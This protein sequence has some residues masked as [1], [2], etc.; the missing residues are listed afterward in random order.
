MEKFY[1]TTTLPYVNAA[2]HI[3]H[4][5]EFT[6]ADARARFESLS[7]KEVFFNTGSDEHGLKIEQQA[8]ESGLSPKEFVDERH[9]P[10]MKLL[11]ALSIKP[12]CFTRTSSE[13]QIKAAQEFWKICSDNGDIYKATYTGKYCVG[14]ELFLQEK[15]LI[16][17]ICPSHPQTKISEVSEENYMFKLSRSR[18]ALISYYSDNEDSIIPQTRRKELLSFIKESVIDIPISRPSGRV[19]WG[20]PVPGDDT[21]TMHV[22]FDALVNYISALGWPNSGWDS[23]WPG[24]Q[25]S[26]KDNLRPQAL[27]WQ[28]MLFSAQ[29]PMTKQ[30]YVHG[31][32]TLNG[33]KM[34][35]TSGNAVDPFEIIEKYGSE[36]ARWLMLSFN[37][38]EDS[39]FSWEKAEEQYVAEFVK[40]VGNTTARVMALAETHLDKPV[41]KKHSFD[42]E[43]IEAFKS[44]N[45]KLAT[46]HVLSQ[47]KKIDERISSKKPFSII[48]ED[49]EKGVEEI[50]ALVELLGHCAHHISPL[51]P[52]TAKI[53]N[54]AI[55]SNKK[56]ASLFLPL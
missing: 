24:V 42:S 7:G 41:I 9:V 34:S 29:I 50:G 55:E 17:G 33:A 19:S 2:P 38:Y 52:E 32:I 40:G 15:D 18:D 53:I 20:V 13:E 47:L 8:K 54:K 48:K 28:G 46:A 51:I 6:L 49:K 44:F 10:F 3:G 31:T 30:L 12:T 14:C 56:P 23:W 25:V 5:F 22:W 21:Q 11:E 26:G 37:A 16:D 35:K 36:F 43:Y 39:D 27:I 45:C 4:A 1:I